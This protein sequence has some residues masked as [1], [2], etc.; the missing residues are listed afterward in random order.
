VEDFDSG[1]FSDSVK[2][3]SSVDGVEMF[4]SSRYDTIG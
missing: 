4:Y 3:A 1:C 2:V